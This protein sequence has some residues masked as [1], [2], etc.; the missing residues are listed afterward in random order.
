MYS[1]LRSI[2]VQNYCFLPAIRISNLAVRWR[3]AHMCDRGVEFRPALYSMDRGGARYI[4]GYAVQVGTVGKRFA[5]GAKPPVSVVPSFMIYHFLF[6][7][8]GGKS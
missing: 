4:Y 7:S 5:Q 1:E 3:Y 8:G 2:Q 6:F